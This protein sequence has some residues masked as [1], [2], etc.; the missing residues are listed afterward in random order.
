MESATEPLIRPYQ[1]HYYSFSDKN[2]VLS[3]FFDAQTELPFYLSGKISTVFLQRFSA[4]DA[5]KRGVKQSESFASL[6]FL[7]S[8]RILAAI[9]QQKPHH[10]P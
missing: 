5:A 2:H 4:I 8:D 3:G 1:P 10:T 7:K 9:S 6:P